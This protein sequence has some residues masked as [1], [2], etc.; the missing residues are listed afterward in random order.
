M[1]WPGIT[2]F[3]ETGMAAL[4]FMAGSVKSGAVGG[5]AVDV[6]VAVS[7]AVG[8]SVSGHARTGH[9]ATN[10]NPSQ[11]GAALRRHPC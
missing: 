3:P 11:A 6:A 10:S 4:R 9:S 2:R 5:V 8:V 1:V 7:V